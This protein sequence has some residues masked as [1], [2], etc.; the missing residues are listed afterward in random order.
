MMMMK[1]TILC[2]DVTSLITAHIFRLACVHMEAYTTCCS[3]QT[4]WLGFGLGG[5]I[6]QNCYVIGVIRVRNCLCWVSFAFLLCQLETVVFHFI[7]RR[8]KYVVLA[9][10]KQNGANVSSY[11]IT[12]TKR[13]C[14]RGVM[15]KAMDCGILVSEFVFQSR[16]YVHFQANTLGKGMNSLILQAMG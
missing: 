14:P 3:F 12:A 9:D 11:S 6:C 16:Y 7:N 5:C 10:N 15:V 1:M 8:S 4:M 13:G 2:G